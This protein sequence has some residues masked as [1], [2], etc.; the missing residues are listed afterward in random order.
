MEQRSAGLDGYCAFV[1]EILARVATLERSFEVWGQPRRFTDK[2]LWTA[3]NSPWSASMDENVDGEQKAW[4]RANSMR[5]VPPLGVTV[6]LSPAI[7]LFDGSTQ[8]PVR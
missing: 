6:N 1:P 7:G 8:R 3:L 4:T 2:P 5:I